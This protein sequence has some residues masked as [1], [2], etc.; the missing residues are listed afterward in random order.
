[1]QLEHFWHAGQTG[2]FRSWLRTIT[3]NRAREFW[4][5]G[6]CR[7]R[8]S[9]GSD[10]LQMIEQLE[11]PESALSGQWNAE[12]D[13]H[14]LRR[15]MTLMEQEFEPSTVRVF[16]RLVLENCKAAEVAAELQMTVAAVYGVKSRVL[17]R[18]REEATGLLD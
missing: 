16:R 1:R 9:G 14:I 2:S 12:H 6:K 8:A 5:S 3:T 18:L 11:D 15:L 17:K 10:F 4:R 13:E 7:A